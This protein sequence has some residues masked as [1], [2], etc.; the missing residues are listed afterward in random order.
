M[1]ELAIQKSLTAATGPLNLNVN[2][3]IRK[4]E[5]VVIYGK[6]GAGKTSILRMLAGLLTPDQGVISV[7]GKVW[8]DS[9]NNFHLAPQLRKPGFVFQDY[10]LFPH[11]SVIKNLEF[12]GVSGSKTEELLEIMEISGLAHQ[13]PERLSGGQR[14]RVAL[15]RALASGSEILLLDEPLSALDQEMRKK[16]R[17]YLREVHQK[18]GLTT[19]MVSH[20]PSEIL[21]LADRVLELRDGMI[22]TDKSPVDFFSKTGSSAKFAFT[23]EILSIEKADIVYVISI[24]VGNDLVRIIADKS[25]I[26]RFCIGE[27]VG[28]GSKAFH[29][30]ITKIS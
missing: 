3:S 30:S 27:K 2:T 14:Q 11:L 28:V 19:L 17:D 21:Q 29:P 15:A 5:F 4:G 9:E 26:G 25:E 18:Y 24:L 22:V 1:I 13:K 12:A 23:G 8:F 6:S 10:A 16:L 7:N 20:D